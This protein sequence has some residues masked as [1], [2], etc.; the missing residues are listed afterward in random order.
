MW[1]CQSTTP[2][3]KEIAG[4][5]IIEEEL[6]PGFTDAIMGEWGVE[7]A[8]RF[9]SGVV[10]VGCHGWY[11]VNGDWLVCPVLLNGDDDAD[12]PWPVEKLIAYE[13]AA[14]PGHTLVLLCCN[15]DH[16]TLHGYPAVWYSPSD[17]WVTPTRF[18]DSAEQLRRSATDKGVV[19]DA[20]GFIQ[21][22]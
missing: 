11:A 20:S 15:V 6:A 4:A 8:E 1:S 22:K 7:C 5:D 10:V 17:V 18:A 12:R 21:A 3:T 19:G 2:S 14:H 13:Q 16:V 9:G